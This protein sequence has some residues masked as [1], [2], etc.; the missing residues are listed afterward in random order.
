MFVH[1]PVVIER[2]GVEVGIHHHDV[3]AHRMGRRSVHDRRRIETERRRHIAVE[4]GSGQFAA[5]D[6]KTIVSNHALRLG[7]RS[8]TL[9]LGVA[10]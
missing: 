1:P 4:I 9:H 6:G 7:H 5:V 3:V 10:A 2:V 8:A